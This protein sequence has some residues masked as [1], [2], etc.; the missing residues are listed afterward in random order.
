MGSSVALATRCGIL[1][2]PARRIRA[3]LRAS[4]GPFQPPFVMSEATLIL[5]QIE[6]GDLGA[7]DELLPLLM[8][9]SAARKS[10]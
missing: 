3:R 10:P 7:A 9:E 6:K 8:T 1:R 2:D 5:Q 4:S